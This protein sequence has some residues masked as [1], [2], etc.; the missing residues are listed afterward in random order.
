VMNRSRQAARIFASGP[1]ESKCEGLSILSSFAPLEHSHVTQMCLPELPADLPAVRKRRQSSPLQTDVAGRS[2]YV[3]AVVAPEKRPL[4]A[5]ISGGPR[6]L[7]D[8]LAPI[9]AGRMLDHSAF[10]WPLV[11]AGTLKVTY[12]LL[13]LAMFR[14]VRPPQEIEPARRTEGRRGSDG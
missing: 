5:S 2:S 6:S 9:A 11:I 1:A 13:H 10:G 4:A 3:I 12:D 14:S 7:A 8:A